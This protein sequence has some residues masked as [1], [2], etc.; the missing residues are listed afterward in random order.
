M[1]MPVKVLVVST[2]QGNNLRDGILIFATDGK[3]YLQ[4]KQLNAS[5][6]WETI[7]NVTQLTFYPRNVYFER[8]YN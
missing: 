2:S 7:T 6:S 1:Q 5:G 8:E 4:I 3:V